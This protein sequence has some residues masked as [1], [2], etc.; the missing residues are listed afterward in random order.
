[1]LVVARLMIA[2][3]LIRR[4]SRGT[5]FRLDYPRPDPAQAAHIEIS[6]AG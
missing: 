3:A 2:G 5:H 6:A 1:M 4:E